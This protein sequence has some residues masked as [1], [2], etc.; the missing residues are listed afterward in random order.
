MRSALILLCVVVQVAV[1]GH[2]VYGRESIVKNGLRIHMATAPIDPRDPFRGDFV[3]LRYPLNNLNSAPN[4]WSMPDKVLGKGDV[5]YAVL[6]KMPSGLYE[7]IQFTDTKPKTGIF[8]RGRKNHRGRSLGRNVIHA[9]FG[10]E[11]L[12]V[13]QGKGKTIEDKRGI[14]G[15]MQTAMEMEIALDSKG[16]AVITDYRWSQLGIKLELTSNFALANN[17]VAV[18]DNEQ[19]SQNVEKVLPQLRVTVQNVSDETITL[20]NPGDNCGFALEPANKESAFSAAANGCNVVGAAD[21]LELSPGGVHL[22]ELHLA[23]P[24]WHVEHTVNGKK[25]SGDIRSMDRAD[26]MM[27]IVYR[28][29]NSSVNSINGVQLWQGDLMSQGFNSRGR[30]D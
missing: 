10:I 26:E 25:R 23:D 7:A 29:A 13:E 1:L 12:F 6:E 9:R 20:N 18:A 15:G 4:Q 5:I 27:R 19:A 21:P 22:I 24:R 30:I 17:S 3:R 14:R 28:A 11:Q 8:I 2:M 16:T